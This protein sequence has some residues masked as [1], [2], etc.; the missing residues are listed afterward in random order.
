MFRPYT[1]LGLKWEW[2][3]SYYWVP[4]VCTPFS[5]FLAFLYV[6]LQMKNRSW[7][8]LS[9]LHFS[10]VSVSFGYMYV[11]NYA[12]DPVLFFVMASGFVWLNAIGNLRRVRA[13]YV[14]FLY[15]TMEPK[16]R[17]RLAKKER[18]R[19]EEKAQRTLQER[20]PEVIASED[21][22]KRQLERTLYIAREERRKRESGVTFVHINEA[23]VEELARLPGLNGIMARGIMNNRED[24]PFRSFDDLVD[25][26]GIR[27]HVLEEAAPFIVYSR[28]ELAEKELENCRRKEA[29]QEV[30]KVGGQVVTRTHDVDVNWGRVVDMEKEST[31]GERGDV[32][33]ADKIVQKEK[34]SDMDKV[35]QKEA[36]PTAAKREKE[37]NSDANRMKNEV[38]T[39]KK[40]TKKETFGRRVDL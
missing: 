1:P 29:E 31:V 35:V 38:L 10:L 6:G 16:E 27:A 13:D 23:S 40:K 15:E 14:K 30:E 28:E 25:R 9:L 3:Q 4:F 11:K 21:A 39:S 37:V 24:G 26:T 19:R 33:A 8:F 20:A 18:K 22:R 36:H 32:H 2:K 7:L 12:E 17:E 5:S 34:H